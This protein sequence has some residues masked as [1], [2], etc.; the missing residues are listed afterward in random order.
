MERTST[1]ETQPMCR[2]SGASYK[3]AFVCFACRAACKLPY[4]K[5]YGDAPVVCATCGGATVHAGR[6]FRRP[7]KT[8]DAEWRKLEIRLTARPGYF[9]SC[10]CVPS[11]RPVLD[12]RTHASR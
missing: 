11:S 2:Y 12:T 6:D 10:G 9:N 7:R 5:T 3:T 4:A 8:D 1:K